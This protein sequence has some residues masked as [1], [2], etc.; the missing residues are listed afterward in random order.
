MQQTLRFDL[1]KPCNDCPFRK[2]A[3]WHGGVFK[4]LI[5]YFDLSKKKELVHTCHKTDPRS[6]SPEGQKYTGELQHCAG[7]LLMMHQNQRLIGPF[8]MAAWLKKQWDRD[9]MDT[10][11]KVFK[12]MKEMVKHYVKLAKKELK[13]PEHGRHHIRNDDGSEMWIS[14]GDPLE[15][16]ERTVQDRFNRKPNRDHNAQG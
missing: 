7:L 4:D 6:D 15:R 16:Y 9:A 10:S 1:K 3:K 12:N 8:Q 14:Y 11:V 13:E 2:D 5:K